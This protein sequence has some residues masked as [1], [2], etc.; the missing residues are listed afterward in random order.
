LPRL[1]AVWP[2]IREGPLLE[3]WHSGMAIAMGLGK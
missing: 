3:L 1:L 2:R